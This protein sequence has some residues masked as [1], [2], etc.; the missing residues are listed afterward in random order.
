MY[1]YFVPC[2]HNL[3][4][5]CDDRV[6]CRPVENGPILVVAS[7][8]G[9]H[10]FGSS[11]RDANTLS[12]D[13]KTSELF[14]NVPLSF[15]SSSSS[16]SSSSELVIA[17]SFECT[18]GWRTVDRASRVSSL[19]WNTQIRLRSGYLILWCGD[20]GAPE[21]PQQRCCALCMK[22]RYLHRHNHLHRQAH[23]ATR[24]TCHSRGTLERHLM[25]HFPDSRPCHT[26]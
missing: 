6:L 9:E 4:V 11:R 13:L 2:A 25:Y 3:A 5:S 21:M 15:P 23:S 17:L 12:E 19:K 26:I 22:T 18:N 16:A 24:E 20:A 10:T 8:S 14:E 7:S 1:C